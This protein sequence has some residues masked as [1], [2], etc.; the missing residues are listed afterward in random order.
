MPSISLPIVNRAGFTE[1][2]SFDRESLTPEDR[3]RADRFLDAVEHYLS[4]GAGR[5]RLGTRGG[6]IGNLEDFAG[7]QVAGY[8]LQTN[9]DVLDELANA[10]EINPAED[11]SL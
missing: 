11:H 5:S 6:H 1:I 7:G 9:T 3:E 10:E 4:G 2:K 8:H